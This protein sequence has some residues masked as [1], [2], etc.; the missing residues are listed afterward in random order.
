MWTGLSLINTNDF[1]QLE[2]VRGRKRSAVTKATMF[3]LKLTHAH[4]HTS[5]T[6]RYMAPEVEF[7]SRYGCKADVFSLAV[8]LHVMLVGRFPKTAPNEPAE[9][10]PSIES[11]ELGAN[12]LRNLLLAMLHGDPYQVR[13]NTEAVP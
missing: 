3:F 10:D 8:V 6:G 9:I 13:N 1:Q 7:D 2:H 4:T 12:G 5:S 11:C